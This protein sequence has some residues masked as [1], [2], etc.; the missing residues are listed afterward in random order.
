MNSDAAFNEVARISELGRYA[1]LDTPAEPAFDDLTRLAAYICATPISLISLVDTGRI[2]F[3]SAVGLAASEIPRIDGFCSS[4]ILTDDLL[5][6]PDAVANERLATHPLVTCSPNVRFYAGAPL[7]TPRGQRIGTLCV[8]DTIPRDLDA[9][10]TDALMALART[11]I[12]QLELRHSLKEH[13]KAQQV[14]SGLQSRTEKQV[15]H[16]T[17][18]L[19][20]AN[21]SLQKLSAQLL[22]ARDE[23]RR[24]I[25]RELHDSTGQVLAALRMT[26]D[27][28][29]KDS[30]VANKPRF[31][32]CEE[33]INLAAADV[34]NLSYLLH[35]PLMD[36]AGLGPAV[37]DY[38]QGFMKRSGLDIRVELPPELP[39]LDKDREI[40]LFRIMQ[41][42]LGNVHRHSGSSTA[43]V[44]ISCL[45]KDAVL[46][47]RDNGCGLPS[48]PGGEMSSG[49]GISSMRER[50]REFGGD[51]QIES[52]KE[53]TVVRAILPL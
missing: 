10:Q 48:K 14:L 27:K 17:G 51:L 35:P 19:A 24:R 43:A 13:G 39:K 16:R 46:E 28:M 21:E 47:V 5:M 4:A 36:E 7:I 9:Q 1:I 30:S 12:T 44:R 49:V 45:D 53:G 50:L 33:M 22:K 40:T 25:A 6:V 42:A 34:R 23:E 37:E 26:L 2:W 11:V 32:E 18:Q 38:V 41:E 29:Q 31:A 15:E 3:K 20:S 52:N 8:I